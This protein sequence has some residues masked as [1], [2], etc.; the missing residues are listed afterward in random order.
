[1]KLNIPEQRCTKNGMLNQKDL[2]FGGLK[3]RFRL[4]LA[5]MWKLLRYMKIDITK[6]IRHDKI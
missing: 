1:M 2:I 3:L 5:V 6:V 4:Y